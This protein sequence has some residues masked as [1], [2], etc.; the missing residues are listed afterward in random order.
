[1]RTHYFTF[2]QDHIHTFDG[3]IFNKDCVVEIT[4]EN[5]RA[6]MFELFGTKWAFEYNSLDGVK[7]EYYSRGIIKID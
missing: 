3:I 5:P 1:M 4:D 6:K 7:L 2:G